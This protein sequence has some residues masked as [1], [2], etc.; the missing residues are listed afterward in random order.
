LVA[1]IGALFRARPAQSYTAESADDAD[2]SSAV[3]AGI[4]LGRALLIT[5]GPANHG[6]AFAK[7]L[8]HWDDLSC[9]RG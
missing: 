6:I 8:A 9:G 5:A 2:E 1:R 4:S 7:D 3:L